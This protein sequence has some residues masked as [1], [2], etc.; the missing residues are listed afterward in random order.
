[1]KKIV[2]KMI[3]YISPVQK[4]ILVATSIILIAFLFPERKYTEYQFKEGSYWRYDDLIAPFNFAV[5]KSKE[6][7]QKEYDDVHQNPVLF[8]TKCP[9]VAKNEKANY[10]TNFDKAYSFVAGANNITKEFLLKKSL[11]WIDAVYKRGIIDDTSHTGN[12]Q[13]IIL[14]NDYGEQRNINEFYTAEDVKRFIRIKLADLSTADSVFLETQLMP[15]FRPNFILDKERTK[16]E[17]DIRLAHIS[18]TSG[19]I[20][21]GELIISREELITPEKYLALASFQNENKT[22]FDSNYST[23]IR[24]IGKLLMLTIALLGLFLFLRLIRHPIIESTKSIALILLMILLMVSITALIYKINDAYL[25]LAPLC[26]GPII[27]RVF[28]DTKAALY[29][30]VITIFIIGSLIPNGFE[31]MYYQMIAGLFAIVSMRSIQKRAGFF[32]AS[33]VVFVV[34][35]LTYLALTLMNDTN[36]KN[37]DY[38]QFLILLFNAFLTMLAYP[39]IYMIEKL[40]GMVSEVSLLELSSTNTPALRDLAAKAPGTFQHSVQVANIAEDLINELGGNASLVRVGALYHDIGKMNAAMYFTENQLTD[41]N[42]HNELTYEE[43]ASVIL[44]HVPDGVQ[45][46]HKYKLPEVIVDFIRTHHGTTRTGYFY[47]K[48]KEAFPNQEIDDADFTYKGPK[49]YSRENAVV[50]LVDSVEAATKSM[51]SHSE[52]DIN[53][54]IERVIDSKIR[55]NQLSNCNITFHDVNKIKQFLKKKMKSIYHVRIEYPVNKE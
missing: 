29:V 31:F 42:P 32:R 22:K 40:F 50:M 55:E 46:G 47:V 19:M 14:H 7:L 12:L 37:L 28:F 20:P 13:V 39:M 11:E 21:A 16:Q 10:K 44:N 9:D 52:E 2:Q 49:P 34:Y 24:V 53:T 18:T 33:L 5:S 8:F 25:L 38:T 36:L 27:V 23:V 26:L 43:S 4:I 3:E 17:L 45:L 6:A 41:F 48:Q 54:M 30:H 15:V 1:M 51:E 35:S